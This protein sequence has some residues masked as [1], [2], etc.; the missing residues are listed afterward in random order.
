MSQLVANLIFKGNF[1]YVTWYPYLVYQARALLASSGGS[2]RYRKM[3]SYLSPKCVTV[4][5]GYTGDAAIPT[6]VLQS[7]G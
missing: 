1:Q 3:S 2:K 6:L 5:Y 7:I 4:T